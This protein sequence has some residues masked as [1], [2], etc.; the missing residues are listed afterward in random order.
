[1]F[2]RFITHQDN[3][4]FE[5]RLHFSSHIVD[6]DVISIHEDIA[7]GLHCSTHIVDIIPEIQSEGTRIM[8]Y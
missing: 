6:V 3:T 8:N 7:K 1:M 4:S 5:R 2:L